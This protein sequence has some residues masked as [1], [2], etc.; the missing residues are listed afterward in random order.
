MHLYVDVK[1]SMI[2]FSMSGTFSLLLSEQKNPRNT[3][4]KVERHV[5]SGNLFKSPPCGTERAVN[6]CKRKKG[7]LKL[8]QSRHRSIRERRTYISE[9]T[10]IPCAMCHIHP[11]RISDAI[12]ASLSPFFIHPVSYWLS[13]KCDCDCVT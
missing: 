1:P 6:P 9:Q 13:H 2:F 8:A 10:S 7:T 5:T 3:F 12:Q 11:T 4:M